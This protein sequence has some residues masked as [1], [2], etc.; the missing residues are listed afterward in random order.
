MSTMHAEYE[1]ALDRLRADMAAHREDAAKRDRD[2]LRWLI[3]LWIAAVVI[4]GV[5]IRL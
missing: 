4:L 1:S 2:N 3:G 5:L